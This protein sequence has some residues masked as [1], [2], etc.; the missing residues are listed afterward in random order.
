[1]AGFLNKVCLIGNVGRGADIR[2]TQDGMRICTLSVATSESWKD[3]VTGEKKQKTEWHRVVVMNDWI[4][5]TIDQY[6][7]TGTRVYVE[8]QLNT[9]KWTDSSG[10]D[11]YTTEITISRYKGEFLLLDKVSDSQEEDEPKQSKI[12]EK[13][14]PKGNE[15]V[16]YHK[17]TVDE[18]ELPF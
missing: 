10:N 1:M 12:E 2:T 5:D 14:P 13:A 4:I 15:A 16:S 9:R 6:V 18:D 3:K 17:S 11:K 7:R 8:G